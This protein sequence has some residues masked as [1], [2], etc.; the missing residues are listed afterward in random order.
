MTNK[1]MIVESPNKVGSIKKYLG[2][3]W[4]V[5]A[6]VGHTYKLPTKNYMDAKDG[7]KLLYEPDPKKKDVLKSLINLA[8]KCDEIYLATDCDVEGSCIAWHLY[9][10]LYKKYKDK[11]KYIRVNLKEITKTGIDQALKTS[12]PVTDPKEYAIVQAGFLRRI[13]DRL[14]GFKISPL[15]FI[16]VKEGTSAGRVQSPALRI[17]VERQREVDAFIPEVYYDIFSDVFP[18]G[19][20]DVFRAKY[21][22]KVTEE[23]VAQKIVKDCKSNPIKIT[24]ITRKQVQSKPPAP[25]ITKTLL[26]SASTILGWKAAKTTNVSQELFSSG[27]I[28]YIRCDN[29]VISGD[30]QKLLL[31][32][33]NSTFPN[34]YHVKSIPNYNI[35]KAKLEHECIR[36]T[37]LTTPVGQLSPDQ[38]KLYELIKRRFVASGL[39][40]AK[41]DGITI[42]IKIGKHEFKASG[43]VLK[44]DGYLRE[45]NFHTKSD[46][47]IPDFTEKDTL[48]LRDVFEERKETKP[49]PRYKDASLIDA[50]EKKGIGKPSTFKSILDILEKR[51]YIK[52][53]KQAL[54]PTDLGLRLNDFLVEYFGDIVD[55]NFTA[56][57]E[58]QQE[59][60]EAG[61]IKYEDAVGEFYDE[62]KKQLKDAQNKIS[63]DKQSDE[64]TAITCPTC[65]KNVLLKKINKSDGKPFYSCVGY[66]D[67]SCMATFSISEDGQPVSNKAEVLQK[68][69][70]KGCGGDLSKRINKR[71]KQIFYAC[72]NWKD[73]CKITAD[74]SGEIKEPK[75]I[76]K[77]NKKCPKCK[78]GELVKRLSRAGEPFGA[79]NQFPRC[80]HTESL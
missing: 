65:N 13:E 78:K 63:K 73:G 19:T 40:P 58:A 15:A 3:G 39:P 68:C 46:T 60:V 62:L 70:A 27:K 10:H 38:A 59:E 1:L 20:K 66:T 2:K 21:V 14:V 30:G 80:K 16:Y 74:E 7:Y 28:T 72:T 44:F 79:C 55:Y 17:I 77:L 75:K 69:P 6:S 52:Y 54:V 42:D 67:K 22:N 8:A 47:I 32:F 61:K 50:L 34:Q 4:E 43:S 25:F 49:P 29:T 18:T 36:P 12:Y 24:K 71:T 76:E 41:Y 51:E 35:A 11:K 56:R 9:E 57:V 33:I 45:W 64:H 53:D 23:A 5:G 48:N 37:D 31:G 26:A